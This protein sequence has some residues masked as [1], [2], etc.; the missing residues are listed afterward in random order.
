ME[1]QMESSLVQYLT[2]CS[3]DALRSYRLARQNLRANATKELRELLIEAIVLEAECLLAT[4]VERRGEEIIC[5]LERGSP[6]S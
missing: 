6:G 2:G 3:K 4:L 1:N 5:G